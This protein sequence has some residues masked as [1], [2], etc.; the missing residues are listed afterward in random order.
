MKIS[1]ENKTVSIEPDTKEEAFLIG[2]ILT[3]HKDWVAV[4]FQ[5]GLLSRLEI[6][7]DKLLL[8]LSAK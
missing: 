7:S 3:K 8:I 4:E 6:E 2:I 5:N 1:Q